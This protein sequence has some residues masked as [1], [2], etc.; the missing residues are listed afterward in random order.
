M[1]RR[2]AIAAA[3]WYYGCLRPMVSCGAGVISRSSGLLQLFDWFPM[4]PQSAKTHSCEI[5]VDPKR[6]CHPRGARGPLF[7]RSVRM[8]ESGMDEASVPRLAGYGIFRRD[9]S[10]VPSSTQDVSL[11]CRCFLAVA[12]K[13]A[14]LGGSSN[15]GWMDGCCLSPR[16]SAAITT[17]FASLHES[18]V[19][20][21]LG[22]FHQLQ[23]TT[24]SRFASS[25]FKEP[26]GRV[27]SK[28]CHVNAPRAPTR[29][30][31]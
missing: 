10:F 11:S 1:R 25:G 21:R 9:S 3:K 7:L 22:S 5:I 30:L 24:S 12:S 23:W 27:T 14:E 16:F 26:V 6:V 2:D 19:P 29:T 28:W 13:R 31:R 15:A 8:R 17:R 20:A 4:K 18:S